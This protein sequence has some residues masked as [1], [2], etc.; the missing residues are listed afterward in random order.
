V[1]RLRTGFD[2][3]G[4]PR[5]LLSQARREP[6]AVVDY[7]RKPRPFYARHGWRRVTL[8]IDSW[9]WTAYLSP[10]RRTG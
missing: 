7:G 2:P 9:H 1:A 8:V 5:A 6:V 4:T 10:P 3:N